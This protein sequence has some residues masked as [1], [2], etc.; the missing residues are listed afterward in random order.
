[1]TPTNIAQRAKQPFRTVTVRKTEAE[2]L[3]LSIDEWRG[4]RLVEVASATSLNRGLSWTVEQR[5]RLDLHQ[6]PRLIAALQTVEAE[7][8]ARGWLPAEPKP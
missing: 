1:M 8:R 4:R 6:L 5:I 2:A 7:A 3:R